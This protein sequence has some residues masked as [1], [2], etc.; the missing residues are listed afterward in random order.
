MTQYNH[1]KFLKL[2]PIGE[3]YFILNKVCKS[4][5]ASLTAFTVKTCLK[6]G[7]GKI[8]ET[9]KVSWYSYH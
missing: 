6:M 8:R 5:Y 3:L 4:I 7:G 9:H 1:F 2:D